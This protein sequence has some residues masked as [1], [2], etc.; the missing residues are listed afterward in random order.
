MIDPT[1]LI[2]SATR[3]YGDYMDVLWG[4]FEPVPEDRVR[5]LTG[6][7]TLDLGDSGRFEVLYTPG[8]AV[9][10]VS[11]VQ[12]D[13]TAFVGDVAGTR[14]P[15]SDVVLPPTPPPD[16]HPPDW[17][18]SISALSQRDLQ[19]LNYTHW[20]SADDV[21]AH[22]G[23]LSERLTRW[24]E[25]AA[26]HDIDAWAQLARADMEAVG[27]GQAE[28]DYQL[29]PGGREANYGGLRRYWDKLAVSR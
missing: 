6:G 1:K 7:E 14:A 9:H 26:A 12:E 4:T 22:L 18:A 25:A 8:H 19:L 24:S 16:I 28:I 27:A 11:Y 21:E 23:Q 2:A 20:G 5:V 13:G 15:G 17:Q 10:H 3:I 29:G